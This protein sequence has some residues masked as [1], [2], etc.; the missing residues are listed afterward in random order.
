MGIKKLKS[1]SVLFMKNL[2]ISCLV[3]VNVWNVWAIDNLNV[4]IEKFDFDKGI[5]IVRNGNAM[6]D[7]GQY[8]NHVTFRGIDLK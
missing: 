4:N 5:I 3:M 1:R 7:N 6:I 8:Y 2:L